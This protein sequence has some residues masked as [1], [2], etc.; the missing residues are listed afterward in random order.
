[1][2][3]DGNP[4]EQTN[5][6]PATQVVDNIRACLFL[7]K[8]RQKDKNAKRMNDI[9]MEAGYILPEEIDDAPAPIDNF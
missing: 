6:L 1:M 8:E 5:R 9:M 3:V 4:T 2:D 7:G